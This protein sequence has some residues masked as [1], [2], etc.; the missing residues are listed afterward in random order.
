VSRAVEVLRYDDAAERSFARLRGVAS[1]VMLPAAVL[2]LIRGGLLGKLLGVAGVLLG[3]LWLRR[4]SKAPKRPVVG[5]IDVTDSSFVLHMGTIIRELRFVHVQE[6][7]ADEDHLVVR[8]TARDGE[9]IELPPGYAGLG[10]EALAERLRK[11]ASRAD[12]PDA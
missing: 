7:E 1:L 6:I 8:I 9:R 10:V 4:A 5:R 11:A 12:R 2:L 3:V